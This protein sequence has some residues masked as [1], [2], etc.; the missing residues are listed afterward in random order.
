LAC[1]SGGA[2]GP[3]QIFAALKGLKDTNVPGGHVKD[4]LDI[5]IIT[6]PPKLT[7]P[8]ISM[9]EGIV[10]VCRCRARGLA[11]C[12]V[13]EK[14]QAVLRGNHFLWAVYGSMKQN[15]GLGERD[16]AFTVDIAFAMSKAAG[17]K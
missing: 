17:E 10:W 15:D 11:P 2:E 6:D 5:I 16:I 3:F 12:G 8:H 13:C 9:Y 7:L 1:P 14:G 4:C